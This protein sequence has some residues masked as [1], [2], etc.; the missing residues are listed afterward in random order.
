MN[1]EEKAIRDEFGLPSKEEK[2]E[3]MIAYESSNL[4]WSKL[5]LNWGILIA[6]IVLGLMRGSG[7]DSIIGVIRCSKMDWILFAIL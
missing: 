6:L 3:Q 2:L 4:Q 7:T 1:S 5:A